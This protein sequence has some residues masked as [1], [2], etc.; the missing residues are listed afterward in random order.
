MNIDDLRYK[1]D[2]IKARFNGVDQHKLLTLGGGVVLLVV[3]TIVLAIVWWPEP[4]L[5]ITR[6]DRE[7]AQEVSSLATVLAQDSRFVFIRVVA[8]PDEN[9]KIRFQ[10]MGSVASDGD[11]E[12]LRSVVSSEKPGSEVSWAV[13][14]APP[15]A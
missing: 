10:L 13:G 4:G 1:F 11:L 3:L 8:A 9:G 12:A 15:D 2:E 7:R 6:E 14:V 5:T